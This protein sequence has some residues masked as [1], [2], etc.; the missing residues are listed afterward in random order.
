MQMTGMDL[1]VKRIRRRVTTA[2]LAERAG[3]KARSRVSQIESL[4]VVPED[5]ARRYL[6][7]LVTF[8][9]VITSSEGAA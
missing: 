1:K 7:A 8:P 5:A 4:A 3:W 9:D 2:E 6:D